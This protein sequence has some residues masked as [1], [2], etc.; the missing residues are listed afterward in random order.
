MLAHEVSGSGVPVTLLH[1]F[2]Q[3]HRSWS[4]LLQRMPGDRRWVRIDLPGHGGSR[5]VRAG[6]AGAAEGVVQVWDALGIERS[7][8]VGYSLGGRAALY[9]AASHPERLLS[10][11]TIG[12][13]AGLEAPER[14]PRLA[15]DQRLA[16]EIEAKGIDW[17]AD[18][19]PRNPM[20]SGVARRRPDL[21]EPLDRMRRSQDAAGV[22]AALREMGAAATDPFWDR[23]GAIEIPSLFVAGAEDG[24]YVEMA[25]RLAAGVPHGRARI[26]PDAGH[27]VHLEQPERFAE[28]L[29]AHLR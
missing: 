18:E 4:D 10:L 19:W 27:S 14:A 29:A 28:L 22:A 23:L 6:I 12:A 26:V 20:F 9:L 15:S 11:L 1:G 25:L 7:H 13:H 5:D 16:A 21:A 8:L 17:L 24:R 2:L 3:D